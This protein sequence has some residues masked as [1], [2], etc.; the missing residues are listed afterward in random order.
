M[1]CTSV[2]RGLGVLQ[3]Y[4]NLNR[5]LI[6]LSFP[7][8]FTVT[9][10]VIHFVV[11]VLAIKTGCDAQDSKGHGHHRDHAGC[12][13]EYN[14]QAGTVGK[15]TRSLCNRPAPRLWLLQ[16]SQ[17]HRMNPSSLLYPPELSVPSNRILWTR[18]DQPQSPPQGHICWY[19]WLERC[20]TRSDK[21][22]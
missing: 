14:I 4:F 11:N 16:M 3:I 19:I 17:Q 12:V 10:P 18:E 8:R 9:Y 2:R 6:S 21:S 1:V 15:L 5:I 22:W 20:Y 7:D 13:S